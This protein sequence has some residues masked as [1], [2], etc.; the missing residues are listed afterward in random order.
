MNDSPSKTSACC[1]ARC[2]AWAHALPR[3]GLALLFLI[4]SYNKLAKYD[5][6]VRGPYREKFADVLPAFLL[7][8]FFHVLPFVELL[9]G[10]LLALGLFTRGAL[11]LAGLTL[12]ALIF[13]VYL[14][15][16]YATTAA[17]FL[18]L[19]AAAVLLATAD[20]AGLGLDC[21]RERRC[22][23]TE[24]REVSGSGGV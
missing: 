22:L 16:D 12:L 5:W 13:G 6:W 8:P 9:V 2:R 17:N 14:I 10:T 21:L 15:H 7:S 23:S 18:Y 19:C 20:H 24:K 3:W 4:A 1:L 11:K